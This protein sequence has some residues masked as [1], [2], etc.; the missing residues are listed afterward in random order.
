V[1]VLQATPLE[2]RFTRLL[3]V[4]RGIQ[5]G[6]H[7]VGGEER[8]KE[9]RKKEINTCISMQYST[10][11]YSTAQHSTA[12]HSTAQHS[13]AQHSMMFLTAHNSRHC[14]T[15]FSCLSQVLREKNMFVLTST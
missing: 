3:H 12:Q 14:S 4:R 1:V 10:V 9:E 2:Q 5:A 6:D 13:T 8:K 15:I 7:L 11:Q